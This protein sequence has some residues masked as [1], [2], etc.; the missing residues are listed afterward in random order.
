VLGIAKDEAN[1]GF[2]HIVLQPTPNASLDYA[3]GSYKSYYGKI[4]SSWVNNSNGDLSSY[5]AVIPANTTASL[6]LPVEGVSNVVSTLGAAYKGMTTHNGMATAEFALSSGGYNFEVSDSGEITVTH[7][8]GY[9]IPQSVGVYASSK[10]LFGDSVEYTLSATY[11]EDVNLIALTFLVDGRILSGLNAVINGLNGFTSFQNLE[12]KSLGDDKWEVKAIIGTFSGVTKSGTMDVAKLR[13]GSIKLGNATITLTNVIVQ[14]IDIIDGIPG[15]YNRM[16]AA[17]PAS[18][19]TKV[20]S[21]YDINDDSVI[22]WDDL[23]LAFYHY[24]STSADANWEY[25]K[26]ADVNGDGK[27]DMVDLVAI[28]ANF[29]Y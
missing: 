18:A 7:A 17:I 16:T 19:T 20:Y 10:T 21:I 14:G 6:Y 11:M 13:L 4:E 15:S 8:P 9:I 24:L 3:R 28:Y 26:V 29:L 1:P 27:V 5:S 12:W 23:S 22:D 2:K 25:A